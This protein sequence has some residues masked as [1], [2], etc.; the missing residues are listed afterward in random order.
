MENQYVPDLSMHSFYM[1]IIIYSFKQVV[2]NYRK[3]I[4]FT[5]VMEC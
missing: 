2:I 4:L 5:L 1:D 3:K